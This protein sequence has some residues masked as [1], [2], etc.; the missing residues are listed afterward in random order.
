LDYCYVS[1][2]ITPAI[3]VDSARRANWDKVVS[4]FS[5]VLAPFT[6]IRI[7]RNFFGI[8]AGIAVEATREITNDQEREVLIRAFLQTLA[9][10]PDSVKLFSLIWRVFQGILPRWR[11]EWTPIIEE[12]ATDVA[13]RFI[14]IVNR[15]DLRR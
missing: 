9:T 6:Q 4:P 15:Y 11:D 1:V 7:N 14:N 13:I 3:F 8:V 12:V 5:H 10:R 2:T